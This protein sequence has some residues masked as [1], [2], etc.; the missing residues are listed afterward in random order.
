MSNRSQA[1]RDARRIE[2]LYKT[3]EHGTKHQT[4]LHLI[5]ERGVD[6]CIEQLEAWGMS[7]S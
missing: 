2:K 6:G 5:Q 7:P 4:V 1:T 3:K